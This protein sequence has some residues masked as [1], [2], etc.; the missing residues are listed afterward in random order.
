[1]S[2]FDGT[3]FVKC[4]DGRT[5]FLDLDETDSIS[6]L[7]QKIEDLKPEP[8]IKIHFSD[9]LTVEID[10]R[11]GNDGKSDA[12]EVLHKVRDACKALRPTDLT[13]KDVSKKL[14]EWDFDVYTATF[15]E[16]KISGVELAKM[17][18]PWMDDLNVKKIHRR[19]LLSKIEEF[20]KFRKVESVN[21]EDKYGNKKIIELEN[22]EV[23]LLLTIS[24][25]C[26]PMPTKIQR[27]IFRG[28]QLEDN[29]TIKSYGITYSFQPTFHLILA[30]TN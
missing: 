5:F 24:M 6:T 1:M 18:L 20:F 4:L 9:G 22:D 17:N 27:I 8:K 10:P 11:K 7:K 28:E 15:E 21:L 12:K 3:A 23:D 16:A 26:A 2:E 13:V 19:S 29:K 25:F 30:R 14:A